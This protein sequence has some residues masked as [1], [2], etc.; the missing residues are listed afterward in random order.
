MP[1]LPTPYRTPPSAVGA[2]LAALVAVAAPAA[3]WSPDAQRAIAADAARL[4]PPD[5]QRQFARHARSLADGAVEPFGEPDPARHVKNEDGSGALDRALAEETEA[6]VAALRSLAPMGELV[7]RLGRVAHWVADLNNPLN[8]STAD[9]EEGRYFRDYF[10]YADSARSR[11]AVVLYEN[12]AV[13]AGRAGIDGLADRALARGRDLYPLIGREYRRIGFGI[14]RERF[15]DRSTAYGVA[16]LAYSHSV[17]DAARLFRYVWLA[18][19]GFD[20]RPVLDRPR[21]RVVVLPKLAAP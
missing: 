12:A 16:A 10:L 15:D 21:N 19:G 13:V 17:S 6:A 1:P 5:L 11:F 8:A 4:A 2:L 3:A 14:G 18:G 7:H 9:P 20:P